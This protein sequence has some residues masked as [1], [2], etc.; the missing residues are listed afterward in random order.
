MAQPRTDQ[1]GGATGAVLEYRGVAYDTGTN[2]AT[3]QGELSR[4]SWSRRQML[5][6]LSLISDQLNCNSITIYGSDLGR[7]RDTAEAAVERD[8]H[9][10]LQPR[11]ADRP[12]EEVLDHLAEAARLAESLRRQQARIDLTVGAVHLL[13]TPGIAEGG[14]YHERMANAYADADHQLLRPT[15]R[16]DFA[17]T[18]PRLN[19]F[20]AR[21][22]GVARQLFSGPVSYSA[23]PFEQVDWSLFDRIALMWQYLPTYHTP[24]QH[25]AVL[26]GYRSWNLP[27]QVAEF[28][29]AT[30]QG[31]EEKA[32]FFWDVV[33]RSGPTP[34]VFDGV[35]RDE[36]RQAAYHLRMFELF[37]QAGVNGVWVSEFIHPTHPHS[38][39]PHLD[40]D[41]AS[42]AIVK[43]IR[44]DFADTA[45]T[46][47]LEPKESFHAIAD[48]YAHLGFQAAR[49]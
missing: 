26:D 38:E 2:F 31:A 12:Q 15:G 22:N 44:D 46:Y 29:T 33:D 25:Q 20:L 18:A 4:M 39:D 11:L 27:I 35:V 3:G 16:I 34:L 19:D 10:R 21:A 42:M 24:Q 41:T 28:G 43:T 9:V 8:L 13:F 14:Q 5:E 45:S 47:R 17:E 6:E 37:E 40:L 30:Y 48:H 1:A 7:L 49:R 36:G 32:F 23:A